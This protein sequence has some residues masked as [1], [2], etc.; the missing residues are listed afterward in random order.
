MI[1]PVDELTFEQPLP[2]PIQRQA[3]ATGRSATVFDNRL[4]SAEAKRDYVLNNHA[5]APTHS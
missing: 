2:Q 5:H 1:Y 3:P 4:R